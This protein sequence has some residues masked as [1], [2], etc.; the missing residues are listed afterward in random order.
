[1]PFASNITIHVEPDYDVEWTLKA[2]HREGRNVGLAINPPTLFERVE[3][4]L[5]H[6]DLLLVMTVNPRFGGQAFIQEMMTKVTRAITCQDENG[7]DFSIQVDGGLNPETSGGAG[8][9]RTFQRMFL[10]FVV[11]VGIVA[12][13]WLVMPLLSN[14]WAMNL[15]LFVL[16]YSFGF[17]TARSAGFSFTTDTRAIHLNIGVGQPAASGCLWHA[18][19]RFPWANNRARLRRSG[20]PAALAGLTKSCFVAT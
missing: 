19:R 1:M 4:F 20:E 16:C 7:L 17:I 9:M 11:G 18:A 8:D 13:L 14:Y 12:V 6:I 3:P 15:L 5:K 10:T 2:I